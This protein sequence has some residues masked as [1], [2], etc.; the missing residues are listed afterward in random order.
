MCDRQAFINS[1]G[2]WR[3]HL[4]VGKAAESEADQD[5]IREI[6]AYCEKS[7]SL[8]IGEA[9]TRTVLRKQP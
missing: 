5:F 7:S 6:P 1:P 9:A 2:C 4:T 3:G 8:S